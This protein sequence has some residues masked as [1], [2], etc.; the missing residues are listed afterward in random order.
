MSRK[1][2]KIATFLDYGVFRQEGHGIIPKLIELP[3]KPYLF[4]NV[5]CIYKERTSEKEEENT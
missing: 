2:R 3:W 5:F 1:P 4:D